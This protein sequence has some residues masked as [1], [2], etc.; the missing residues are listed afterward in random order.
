MLGASFS[1]KR[2]QALLGGTRLMQRIPP[3]ALCERTPLTSAEKTRRPANVYI[4]V[5]TGI[6]EGERA[7]ENLVWIAAIICSRVYPRE[8]CD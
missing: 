8:G 2:R 6:G 3:R 4:L 5:P 1:S 7:R